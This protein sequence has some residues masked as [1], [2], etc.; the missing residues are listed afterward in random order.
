MV[1]SDLC[2]YIVKGTL[3]VTVAN[4]RDRKNRSL[5]LKN[6]SP[7]TS[8]ISKINNILIYNAEDLDVVISIYYLTEYGKNYRK[9]T[10]SLWNYYKDEPNNPPAD[11]YNADLIT[12]SVS[13]NTKAIHVFFFYRKHF[14]NKMSLKNLKSLRKY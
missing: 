9:T 13:S 12:N 3:T 6:N 5:V 8:F 4:N 11:N 10:G 1:Q 2:D 7:F 14:Y